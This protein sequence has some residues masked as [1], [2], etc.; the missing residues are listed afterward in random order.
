MAETIPDVKSVVCEWLSTYGPDLYAFAYRW[1]GDSQT[2]DDIVQSVF[3]RVVKHFA[4]VHAANNIRSYLL[5]MTRNEAI[6]SSTKGLQTLENIEPPSVDE[7]NA[8]GDF[9]NRD[10][11]Q[12][13]L[14]KL[15]DQHREILL[16]YYFEEASY[17]EIAESCAIPIG[18]VMS[19]LSRAKDAFRSALIE[20]G[21]G[22]LMKEARS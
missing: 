11:V 13:V 18:T 2:A 15:S 8:T 22:D 20:L 7:S 6:R 14:Q 12:Q 10:C 4:K 19:R 1:T 17:Q 21:V 3:V 16:R 9:E 5:R